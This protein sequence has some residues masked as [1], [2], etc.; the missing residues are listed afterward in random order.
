MCRF[1][2]QRT[3]TVKNIKISLKLTEEEV[4]ILGDKDQIQRVLENLL[5]NSI[6]FSNS[7][8]KVNLR[9]DVMAQSIDISVEDNGIGILENDLPIVSQ[10]F[11]RGRN[12]SAYTGSGLGLAIV[13]EV[14]DQHGAKLTIDSDQNGTR[15][16]MAFL[17]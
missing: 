9:M 11:F 8:G 3:I 10:R 1:C 7:D 15:V 4:S 12:T 14:L 13:K 17:K 6:K 16:T 2:C 5:D